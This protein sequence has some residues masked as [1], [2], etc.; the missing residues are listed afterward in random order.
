[1]FQESFATTDG[2]VT[3]AINED[4]FFDSLDVIENVGIVFIVFIDKTPEET[5]TIKNLNILGCYKP[6][7]KVC[8]LIDYP[9]VLETTNSEIVKVQGSLSFF[10]NDDSVH[11][12]QNL[13]LFPDSTV[14]TTR[15]NKE[16]LELSDSDYTLIA[17]TT[18]LS[19]DETAMPVTSEIA[20][21]KM[22]AALNCYPDEIRLLFKQSDE[23][24]SEY[25]EILED[26]S[27]V[28]VDITDAAS[29]SNNVV[30]DTTT[31]ASLAV[32]YSAFFIGKESFR[33]QL[34]R[35][36]RHSFCEPYRCS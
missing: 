34:Q 27:T 15:T 19:D 3:L 12:I 14:T 4:P 26:G 24:S 20:L 21:T 35:K 13:I 10:G 11:V 22:D 29:I 6:K 17:L 28:K 16:E 32:S 18:E 8:D 33:P 5:V 30:S 23:V 9:S 1:M 31:S 36:L 2:V 7:V 25:L